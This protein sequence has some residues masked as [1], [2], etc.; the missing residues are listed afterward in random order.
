MGR[1]QRRKR[2]PDGEPDRAM[3]T[4]EASL[5]PVKRLMILLRNG[6]VKAQLVIGTYCL[7]AKLQRVVEPGDDADQQ[8]RVGIDDADAVGG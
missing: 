3:A 7:V 2:L 1:K 5:T 6:G 8:A 4:R